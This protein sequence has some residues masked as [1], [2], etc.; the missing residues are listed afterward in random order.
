MGYS[1]QMSKQI[2]L[3]QI[4]VQKILGSKTICLKNMGTKKLVVA[5]FWLPI[6]FCVFQ[7]SFKHLPD[8]F[9]NHSR[10][11]QERSPRY[12]RSQRPHRHLL[13]TW[14]TPLRQ[15]WN[16]LK[17]SYRVYNKETPPT[18]TETS[19]RHPSYTL[20]IKT[21]GAFHSGRTFV[22]LLFWQEWDKVNSTSN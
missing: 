9:Q 11:H 15:L 14:Q 12:S 17:T 7:T 20:I 4:F 3:H 1:P 18:S 6:S 2:R 19:F 8:T 5:I 21:W 13:L 10:N 16:T 22:F